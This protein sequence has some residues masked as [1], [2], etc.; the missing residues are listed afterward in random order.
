MVDEKQWASAQI[1]RATLVKA[2][3]FNYSDLLALANGN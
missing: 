3:N 1:D 2:G